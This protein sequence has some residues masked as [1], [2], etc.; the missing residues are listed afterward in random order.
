LYLR[1]A[2][3]AVAGAAIGT[4][5]TAATG[6]RLGNTARGH[7]VN[8]DGTHYPLGRLLA[9]G[10]TGLVFSLAQGTKLLKF[11]VTFVAKI[12]VYRHYISPDYSLPF[13]L[14]W[15]KVNVARRM[16]RV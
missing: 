13:L 3:A 12:F 2:G 9:F 4:G 8:G 14:W 16:G 5:T 1:S 7:A 10:A 11:L 15:V 6:H